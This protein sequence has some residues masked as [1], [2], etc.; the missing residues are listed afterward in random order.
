VTAA[1]AG[2]SVQSVYKAL[3]NKPALLKTVFDVPSPRRRGRARPSPQAV[4]ARGVVADVSPRPIQPLVRA[5][6]TNPEAGVWEPA[7]GG[8]T[9]PA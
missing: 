3:G 8:N 5:A 6:A 1:A 9:W 4:A 2:V 7:A